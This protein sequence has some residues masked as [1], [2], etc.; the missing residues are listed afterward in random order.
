MK[1]DIKRVTGLVQVYWGN[2][3]GKTTAALGLCVRALGRGLKVHLVQFMKG[4]IEGNKDFE[5]YG[6]LMSLKDFKNFSYKRFGMKKWVV[7]K[8]EP[9]H[10][11]QAEIA[12]EHSKKVVSS[13]VYDVVV[14]D[15]I[16]YAI[17]LG[18]ITESDVLELI[19]SKS[20]Y[21]ELVLTGSH[22]PFEA[23]FN[24]AD[25]VTEMKKHKHPFDVGI[26]ARKGI[27]F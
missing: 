26:P 16:L 22:I 10:L 9:D 20:K 6:E 4:G 24:M 17:Q 18:L 15:E 14:L 3:K 5:E 25:L 7:G 12:L 8:P 11:A 1:S 19:K 27:E 23:V 21:S 13:G 2:G